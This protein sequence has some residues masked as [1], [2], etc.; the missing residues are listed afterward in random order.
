MNIE[1]DNYADY[2]ELEISGRY[3]TNESIANLNFKYNA[4]VCGYSVNNLPINFFNIG[5]GPIKILIWSKCMEMNLHLQ[6]HFLIQFLFSIF[7]SLKC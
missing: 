3:I 5:S 1:V 2:K 7:M 4:K 6:K